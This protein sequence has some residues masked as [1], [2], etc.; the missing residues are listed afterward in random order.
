MKGKYRFGKKIPR[1]FDDPRPCG[2]PRIRLYY[3]LFTRFVWRII[4][5]KEKI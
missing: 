1:L 5:G 3:L 2:I 4:K